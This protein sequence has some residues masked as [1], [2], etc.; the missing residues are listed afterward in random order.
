MYW[1]WQRLNIHT[2]QSIGSF[3]YNPKNLYRPKSKKPFKTKLLL[4]TPSLLENYRFGN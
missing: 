2:S 1:Y 3:K 4:E